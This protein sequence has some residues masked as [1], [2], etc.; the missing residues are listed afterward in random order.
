[1]G[2]EQ[3]PIAI[4]AP[5]PPIPHGHSYPMGGNI[6]VRVIKSD[7]VVSLDRCAQCWGFAWGTQDLL[8]KDL[9]PQLCSCRPPLT[10]FRPPPPRMLTQDHRG[11]YPLTT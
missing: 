11:K 8:R 5:L 1:M 3:K 7:V 9:L 2:E 4:R 6:S 10:L